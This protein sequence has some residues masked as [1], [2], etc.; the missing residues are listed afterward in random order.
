VGH[1]VHVTRPKYKTSAELQWIFTQL[2]LAMSAGF[3]PLAGYRIV[4]TKEME[5]VGFLQSKGAI[6]LPPLINEEGK[7]DSGFLAER[8][9]IMCIAQADNGQRCSLV[10]ELLF[11]LAQLRDVLAAEDSTIVAQKY[12]NRVPVGPQ[13]AKS[14]RFAINIRQGHACKLAAEGVVHGQIFSS[15]GGQVSR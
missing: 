11:V 12:H 9:R 3:G 14:H 1:A 7:L 10:L 15:D 5:Q 2:A 13:R 6:G 8:T 4:F